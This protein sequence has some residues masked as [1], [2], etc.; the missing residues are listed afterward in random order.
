MPGGAVNPAGQNAQEDTRENGSRTSAG[1]PLSAT[2]QPAGE[3]N[4]IE[5]YQGSSPFWKTHQIGSQGK[6]EQT[7]YNLGL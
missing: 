6:I 4:T 3:L 7:K 2:A 1:W 5:T